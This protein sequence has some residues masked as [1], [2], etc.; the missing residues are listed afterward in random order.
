MSFDEQSSWSLRGSASAPLPTA[1]GVGKQL[2]EVGE[3]QGLPENILGVFYPY[4]KE[5][6]IRNEKP[7][8]RSHGTVRGFFWNPVNA[9]EGPENCVCEGGVQTESGPV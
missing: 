8:C 3:T 9:V 4:L 5:S 7:N 1:G 6:L 2:V